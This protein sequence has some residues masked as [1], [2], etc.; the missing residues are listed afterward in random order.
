ME[1]QSPSEDLTLYVNV[2]EISMEL[3]NT[4]EANAID[5]S[6]QVSAMASI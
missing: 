5:L 3:S 6:S 4:G 2:H 1:T